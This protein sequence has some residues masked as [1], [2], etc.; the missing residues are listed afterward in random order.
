MEFWVAIIIYP[1]GRYYLASTVCPTRQLINY[2][3]VTIITIIIVGYFHRGKFHLFRLSL[4]G[5]KILPSNILLV[6]KFTGT[7]VYRQSAPPIFTLGWQERGG[8]GG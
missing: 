2:A 5:A 4:Q 7:V 8:G 3:I 1:M 6:K